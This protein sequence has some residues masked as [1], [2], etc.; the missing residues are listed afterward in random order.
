MNGSGTQA[1]PFSLGLAA[2]ALARP[3]LAVAGLSKWT[4]IVFSGEPRSE[5]AAKSHESPKTC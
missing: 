1:V 2:P 5:K 3:G 4:G